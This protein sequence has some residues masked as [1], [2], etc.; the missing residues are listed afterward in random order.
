MNPGDYLVYY[1]SSSMNAMEVPIKA[2][3][4]TTPGFIMYVPINESIE[5]FISFIDAKDPYTNGHSKR[6]AIYTRCIA[7]EMG[8]AGEELEKNKGRQFDPEIAEIMLRLL[9]EDKLPSISETIPN[10][11]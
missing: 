7:E 10:N 4:G 11:A 5:T 8:Y 6:V 3:E 2:Y 1:P 9:R